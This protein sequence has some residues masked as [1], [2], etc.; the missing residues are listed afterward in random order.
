ML[1]P[2][3]ETADQVIQVTVRMNESIGLDCQDSVDLGEIYGFGDKTGTVACSVYTN[4]NDGYTVTIDTMSLLALNTTDEGGGAG[5]SASPTQKFLPDKT[6]MLNPNAAS[7]A[8]SANNGTTW[9]SIGDSISA[10]FSSP[11]LPTGDPLTVTVGVH[12]GSN[13]TLESGVYRGSF[14]LTASTI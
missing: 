5:G 13:A 9:L 12:A 14:T 6:T 11:S 8:L 10:K 3:G 4:S 2:A 1:V 7:W